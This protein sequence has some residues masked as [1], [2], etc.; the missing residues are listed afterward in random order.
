VKS[1]VDPNRV[2]VTFT[3]LGDHA[4]QR[5]RDDLKTRITG[6]VDA[7]SRRLKADVDLTIHG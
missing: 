1:R 3:Y 6:A 5:A 2:A 7:K 4:V